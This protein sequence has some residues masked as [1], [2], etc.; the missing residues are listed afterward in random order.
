MLPKIKLPGTSN[1]EGESHG[2]PVDEKKR[3]ASRLGGLFRLRS[4]SP[5][6][7]AGRNGRS[8]SSLDLSDGEAAG[9]VGS[10]YRS[11]D[12]QGGEETGP[13]SE[14]DHSPTT[15]MERLSLS[16]PSTTSSNAPLRP[17]R[18]LRNLK[19][20][21]TNSAVLRP[22]I[23]PTARLTAAAAAAA[24]EASDNDLGEHEYAD[25]EENGRPTQGSAVD[26]D[27]EDLSDVDPTLLRNTEANAG[28]RIRAAEFLEG[29]DGAALNAVADAYEDGPNM[30]ISKDTVLL[31]QAVASA[32]DADPTFPTIDEDASSGSSSPTT[33]PRMVPVG[34]HG[35][36]TISPR[37]PLQLVSSRPVFERNRCTITLTQGSPEHYAH[38][39]DVFASPGPSRPS[40]PPSV[41]PSDPN[42]P[43]SPSES[44]RSL[45]RSKTYVV[46]SDL[47]EEAY[48]A[49]EWA[50]GTVLRNGDELLIVTVI[51]TDAKCELACTCR[52]TYIRRLLTIDIAFLL[53][54]GSGEGE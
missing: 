1:G 10:G 11:V 33:S 24:S 36:R 17:L 47:S 44:R 51:E 45:R 52:R 48:Y 27:V 42:N 38:Q 12:G 49:I 28:K 53:N 54:S 39:I 9:A 3:R 25:D 26:I 40:T 31:L 41:Q 15:S 13:E 16:K 7:Y 30:T 18:P 4:R 23:R 8:R 19:P 37:K 20:I 50:I 43:H 29:P 34:H 5:G 46:A 22:S 6:P 21:S 14:T 32:H 35:G 2:N